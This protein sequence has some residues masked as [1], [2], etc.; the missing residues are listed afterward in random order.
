M[1]YQAEPSRQQWVATRRQAV[2]LRVNG[3]TRSRHPR[4]LA[5]SA[6]RSAS[7]PAVALVIICPYRGAA[8][9]RCCR[10]SRPSRHQLR[11]PKD[12]LLGLPQA[13]TFW[14]T[15]PIGES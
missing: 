2:S 6:L 7:V 4:T 5:N 12:F 10:S 14:W 15:A 13:V 9:G 3:C 1:I 11:H 8:A